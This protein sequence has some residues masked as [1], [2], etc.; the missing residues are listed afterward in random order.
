[1]AKQ[2][3]E[4]DQFKADLLASP[5]ELKSGQVAR[6]TLEDVPFVVSALGVTKIS[7]PIKT[8]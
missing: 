2:D 5:R 4:L 3:N 7:P 8:R 6:S 1:M